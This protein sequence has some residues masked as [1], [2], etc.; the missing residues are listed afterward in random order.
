VRQLPTGTVTF[1]FSDIEGSTRML[2]DLGREDYGELQDAHA[3]VMR[4]AIADAGGLEIRTEGDAFFAVFPTA[5]G[6]FRAAVQAQRGLDAHP[7]PDGRTIRVRMGLHTGEGTLGGDDYLGIDVNKA[8]RIAAVGH[9]G[10]VLL[11]STT[12]SLIAADLPADITVRDLGTHRLKDFEVAERLHDLAVDGLDA[13]FPPLRT[14]D[15]RRTVLPTPRTSF[16]GRQRT[17][18]DVAEALGVSRLTTLTGPGGTGKTRLAI[19]TAVATAHRFADGVFFVDLSATTEGGLI[20]AEVARVLR[21]RETPAEPLAAVADH[22][23]DQRVL[24]ILDNMEQLVDASAVVGDLIDAVPT[25]TVLVTSR[26]PLRLAGERGYLV[27]PLELPDADPSDLEALSESDAIRLFVER[28]A[29]ARQGFR[30]DPSNAA[31]IVQIVQRLDAL[32]LAIEL[33]ASRLR[34]LD[35]ASLASR[36]E[37]RLGVLTGGPRDAPERHRTLAASIRWSEESLE[38]E[39]RTLFARLAVFAGGWTVEAAEA[40][41]GSDLDV[42]DGLETLVDSSLVRRSGDD[43]PE[44]RFRMLETIREYATERLAGRPDDE[45][46]E[47]ERRHAAIVRTLAV[48]AEPHLTKDDQLPWLDRLEREHDNLRALFERAERSAELVPVALDAAASIWRFWQQ[49]GFLAEGRRRLERLLSLPSASPRDTVRARA[50]GALGSVE[51]WLS[52]YASMAARYDEAAAIADELGDRRL[53]A[54]ALFDQSFVWLVSGELDRSV[55][56]LEQALSMAAE[57]DLVL[58]AKIVISIAY[59]RLF[60]GDHVGGLDLIDEAIGMHGAAGERLALA[61]AL[62]ARAGLKSKLG[63]WDAATEDLEAATTVA[64]EAPGPMLLAQV[65]IPHALLA[66]HDQRF[67]RAAV[68]GGAWES[69]EVDHGVHFPEVA[70]SFLGDPVADARAAMDAEAFEEAYAEGRAMTIDEIVAFLSDPSAS[71]A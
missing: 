22:L 15:Q 66:V 36:L 17:I 60:L 35:P 12:A 56:R 6:A 50:L 1:L 68:V 53:I 29:D 19:E 67:R 63:E 48:D 27:P 58:R 44:L 62:I 70:G 49:R 4:I 65:V 51:Y 43:E 28:A 30:L 40:V 31:A 47:L 39:V 54:R 25:L 21:A 32:P 10:Q 9:G 38:P 45:R 59:A 37:H 69:I 42:L 5:T 34:V 26:I 3:D 52:D 8:A 2:Q 71:E 55:E 11:S 18:A 24:L 41:C 14:M 33:A 13:T 16:V 7:W 64:A 23:R 20:L 57:D 61:E 46:R